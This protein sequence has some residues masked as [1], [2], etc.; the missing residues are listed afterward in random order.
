MFN[1]INPCTVRVAHFVAHENWFAVA[2]LFKLRFEPLQAFTPE[3]HITFTREE[4]IEP[5]TVELKI[6]LIVFNKGSF[7]LN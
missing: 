3:N 5:A 6:T 1:L 7:A 4:G 2:H